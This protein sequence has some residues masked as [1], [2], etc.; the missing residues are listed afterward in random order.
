MTTNQRHIQIKV[1]HAPDLSFQLPLDRDTMARN[2]DKMLNR[3]LLAIAVSA[4]LVVVVRRS[5]DTSAF[6]RAMMRLLREDI[7]LPKHWLDF[8]Y[9]VSSR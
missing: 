9:N 4:L 3:A 7:R 2:L 6:D 5:S 1:H 8:R